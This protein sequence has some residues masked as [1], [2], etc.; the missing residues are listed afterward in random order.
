MPLND[1][2]DPREET[3]KFEGNALATTVPFVVL[4]FNVD[5]AKQFRFM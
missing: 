2:P 5:V 3:L 4:V 1:V